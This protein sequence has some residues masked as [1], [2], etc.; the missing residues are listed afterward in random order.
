MMKIVEFECPVTYSDEEI[1]AFISEQIRD[2]GVALP[3]ISISRNNGLAI[4]SKDF[5]AEFID[6][7]HVSM[8][9]P[10]KKDIELPPTQEI[11]ALENDVEEIKERK[12]EL[13]KEVAVSNRK[14]AF[15]GCP[16]CKSRISVEYLKGRDFCPVC[17]T[18]LRSPTNLK[19]IQNMDAKILKYQKMLDE[20][21]HQLIQQGVGAGDEVMYV[22]LFLDIPES[23]SLSAVTEETTHD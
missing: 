20:K 12:S 6:S 2:L 9:I 17:D 10:V 7:L 11:L 1:R 18:D 5:A 19:R 15:I 23:D 3:A 16:C 21:K 4:K 22:R 8:A 13:E 14:S